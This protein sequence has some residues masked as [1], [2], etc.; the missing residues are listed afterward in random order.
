MPSPS[1]PDSGST[2]EPFSLFRHGRD[3]GER[4]GSKGASRCLSPGPRLCR[5]G[6]RA[7]ETTGSL[8]CLPLSFQPDASLL[9]CRETDQPLEAEQPEIT[10]MS[11]L[12]P[13]HASPRFEPCWGDNAGLPE[14]TRPLLVSFNGIQ[15]AAASSRLAIL[16]P[17][18]MDGEPHHHPLLLWKRTEDGGGLS[19]LVEI[20]PG[21]I[22]APPEASLSPGCPGSRR[23]HGKLS[24]C[25]PKG[26][27]TK[28]NTAPFCDG[29]TSQQK[30]L[31]TC[32]DLCR[33]PREGGSPWRPPLCYKE[34]PCPLLEPGSQGACFRQ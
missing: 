25:W 30:R 26:T 5:T 3:A 9:G 13:G 18:R 27:R 11:L 29:K 10:R 17:R 14:Q 8:A 28:M 31:F 21:W 16:T 34:R 7:F 32:T 19:L 20:L 22:F 24:K 6:M 15:G 1:A 2:T 33:V 23:P 4:R 12:G